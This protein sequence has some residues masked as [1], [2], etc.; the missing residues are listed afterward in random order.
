MY[1]Q[2]HIY[3]T[4]TFGIFICME[5]VRIKICAVFQDRYFSFIDIHTNVSDK[6]VSKFY[7]LLIYN[8]G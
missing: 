4:L 3:R 8:E 1:S 6:Y 2:K 7:L 5:V